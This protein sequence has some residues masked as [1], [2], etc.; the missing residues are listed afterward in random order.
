[1]TRHLPTPQVVL[2]AFIVVFFLQTPSGLALRN[3]QISLALLWSQIIAIALPLY[4]LVRLKG[5]D[6][7]S[8]FPLRPLSAPTAALIICLTIGFTI[9]TSWIVVWFKEFLHTPPLFEDNFIDFVRVTSIDRLIRNMGLLV[10]LPA[11]VEESFFRGFCQTSLT[12]AYGPL[13]GISLTSV[14]FALAHGNIPYF[15]LYF[16]LGVYLGLLRQRGDSLWWSILAHAVNN[17]WTLF[18]KS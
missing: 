12:R 2:G 3:G 4:L 7:A 17:A 18:Q 10:L 6:R 9:L 1:M 8:L 14:F 13:L 15:P 16:S 5:W 11:L